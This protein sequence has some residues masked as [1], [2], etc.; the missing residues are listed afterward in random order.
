MANP[1]SACEVKVIMG[2]GYVEV[3]RADID[4]VLQR[5]WDQR[6]SHD[7]PVKVKANMPAWASNR[8]RGVVVS[9]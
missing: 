4:K 9:G 3:K 1:L 6:L 7:A 8:S 2:K 5:C